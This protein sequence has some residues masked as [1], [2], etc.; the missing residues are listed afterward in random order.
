MECDSNYIRTDKGR[1][2]YLVPITHFNDWIEMK[3]WMG[4]NKFNR[5]VEI[6]IKANFN[7]FNSLLKSKN[8]IEKKILLEKMYTLWCKMDTV[9]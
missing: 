9:W 1:K 4:R 3:R 7:D 6:L 2:K 8:Q 5:V